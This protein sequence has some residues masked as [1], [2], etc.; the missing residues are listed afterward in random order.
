MTVNLETCKETISLTFGDCGENH[1]GM[2]KVG[3]LVNEGGGFSI[4]DLT[5][6]KSILEG[7]GCECTIY[8]LKDNLISVDHHTLTTIDDTYV[9]VVRDGLK[10]ILEINNS[11]LNDLYSEMNSFEWDRKYFD[12]RRQKVLNKH[13][14]ANV[15]FGD[16]SV[17]PDYENKKGRVVGY[18]SVQS[19]RFVK[20]NLSTMF[21]EKCDNLI[22]E[23]NRYFDL[24]KCGIGYHGDAE[25]RKVVAFRLGESMNLHFNWFYNSISQG[26]TLKLTLNNGDMYMMSEKAVGNDWKKR[27]IYTLR[28][29]AGRE[30]CSYLQL[31]AP[32]KQV[33]APKKQ[34]E[35]PKK[36]VEAPKKP[37]EAPKKPVEAS[38]RYKFVK[39]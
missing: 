9:L 16:E 19:L 28:H 17:E 14:R 25:R 18:D 1:V 8:N 37:V 32:K 21:G 12:T 36:P 13:A 10:N 2:E 30:G 39:K 22:C 27:S 11:S 5:H 15:C 29:S 23:G 31:K 4:D 20:E 24:K 6:Y 3:E 33:E 7:I 38:K 35:A 34:V 26:E